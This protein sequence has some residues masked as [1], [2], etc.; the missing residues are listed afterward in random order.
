MAGLRL[1]AAGAA[2]AA[3]LPGLVAFLGIA[4]AEMR[5]HGGPVRALAILADGQRAVSGSFD[6]SAVVWDLDGE[7]ALAVLRV[8]DGAVNAVA[9]LPDGGFATGAEDGRI[10]IFGPDGR[11]PARFL[12]PHPDPITALAV[13]P[14]G[15][16]LASASRD[17]TVR[18]TPLA[19]GPAATVGAAAS[20]VHALAFLSD[21]R[22]VT[23][24]ADLTVRIWPDDGGTP[25]TVTLPAPVNAL[26]A[27]AGGEI[28]AGGADG[29]V[30]ILRPDGSVRAET[31]LEA[32][33]LV[34]LAAAPGG[35]RLAA[36]A[37]RGVVGLLDAASGRIE[38]R[39][40]GPGLPVWS[41][42]F[43]RDGAQLF[44]GGGDRLVRRWDARTGEHLGSVILARPASDRLPDGDPRGAQVFGAC[45]ACHTLTPDGG[46]RA[47]PTLHGLF[48][49]RIASLPGYNFSPA[50]KRLDIVWSPETVSR[51]FEVGP[52]RYTPG[53]KMPEQTVS[54]EDRAALIR[55]L[56]TATR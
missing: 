34:A 13:A 56:E 10:A 16:R 18:L 50:L 24:G 49:R 23:G 54:A 19:G 15:R 3:A 5:G 46:N 31:D 33:P 51:L 14:D 30:R 40:V 44:T 9:A 11:E 47:G 1:I 2:L 28:A 45:A 41:L 4:Q 32:G 38:A 20:P 35:G 21:G 53:T 55:F 22:L 37:I 25:R 27:L 43:A 8:H 36:A 48:G 52:A 6:Q 12:D 7:T 39:L 17:G 26:A 29:V 42:A